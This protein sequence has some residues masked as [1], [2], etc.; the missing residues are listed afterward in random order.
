MIDVS[1]EL[2][3]AKKVELFLQK[4]PQNFKFAMKEA[5][6]KTARQVQAELKKSVPKE[7]GIDK[8]F[9]KPSQI[10]KADQNIIEAGI[11]LRGR[12]TPFW[13]F[14]SVSPRSIMKGNTRDIGGVRI[15]MLGKTEHYP[16]A[17][18][19]NIG[20]ADIGVYERIKDK[21]I[22][23]KDKE[24]GRDK[25]KQATRFLTHM[26]VADFVQSPETKIP[27]DTQN[28]A[29][30]KFEENFINQCDLL[31]RGAGYIQ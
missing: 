2:E 1:V 17:F 18:I 29:Q 13:R 16:H 31:L 27:K 30:N 10:V 22:T 11:K 5:I 3:N 26:S 9:A 7:T 15:S 28:F 4:M 14:A 20:R 12:R 8:E 6:N 21:F 25:R 23:V 19:S 24:T